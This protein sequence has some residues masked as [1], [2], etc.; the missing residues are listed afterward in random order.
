MSKRS[1]SPAPTKSSKKQKL[2]GADNTRLALLYDRC[3]AAKPV[4]GE[5]TDNELLALGVTDKLP[6]LSDICNE[7]L[8][9]HLLSLKTQTQHGVTYRTRSKATAVE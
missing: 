2:G 1:R 5:F 3:I 4:G 9:T 6:E 7:L 8:R